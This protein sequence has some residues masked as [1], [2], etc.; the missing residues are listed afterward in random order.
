M[1]QEKRLHAFSRRRIWLT[2][3]KGSEQS[4]SDFGTHGRVVESQFALEF[5]QSEQP[6]EICGV[7]AIL[8]QKGF[9]VPEVG[10][11]ARIQEPALRESAV[12]P[13][14]AEDVVNGIGGGDKVLH[15]RPI[16]THPEKFPIE[17]PFSP[18]L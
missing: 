17:A 9:C 6:V 2:L 14:T 5:E 13:R 11:D 8:D 18:F 12:E 7:E 3:D 16:A 4:C 1:A 10:P 15:E